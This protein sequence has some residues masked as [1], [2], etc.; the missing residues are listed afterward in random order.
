M[1]NVLDVLGAAF[2][3]LGCSL[4]LVAALALGQLCC[5]L[6]TQAKNM[7][8]A[9]LE[10]KPV[11]TLARMCRQAAGSSKPDPD[12]IRLFHQVTDRCMWIY[13]QQGTVSS[14]KMIGVMKYVAEV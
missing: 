5:T 14:E 10:M 7:C 13:D 1:D 8:I 12:F 6:V 9:S 11:I 4:T 2:L 3:I